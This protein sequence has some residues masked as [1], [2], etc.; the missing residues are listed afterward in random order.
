MAQPW[1]ASQA[2]AASQAR[3]SAVSTP[4]ILSWCTGSFCQLVQMRQRQLRVL[5]QRAVGDFQAQRFAREIMFVNQSLDASDQRQRDRL[6]QSQNQRFG[7]ATGRLAT[8]R[9]KRGNRKA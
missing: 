9:P 7:K 2:L 8:R 3:S 6:T 4:S 5:H 1:A